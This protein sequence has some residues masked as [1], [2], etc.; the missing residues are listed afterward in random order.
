MIATG[1]WI[2]GP[3]A[4]SMRRDETVAGKIAPFFQLYRWLIAGDLCL[5]AS[6][7]IEERGTVFVKLYRDFAIIALVMHGLPEFHEGR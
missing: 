5:R 7:G 2:T 6:V 3:P 4:N 1:R